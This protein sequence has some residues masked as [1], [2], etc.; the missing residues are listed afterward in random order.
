[1]SIMRAGK[2]QIESNKLL[3][4]RPEGGDNKILEM[5]FCDSETMHY[6][7][8]VWTPD[9]VAEALEWWHENWGVNNC[10]YGI[11]LIKDTLES[12]GT[13]G[14]T[15][16]S[17]PNEPGLELSWFVLP[18]YQRQGFATEITTELIRFAF[19][20][21]KAKRLVAETHP[22]NPASKKVLEKLHFECL[23][24]RQHSYDYL[25]GF[26]KQVLWALAQEKWQK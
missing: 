24:E 5:L 8:G 14:F 22:D 16:S 19:D 26:D 1:M 13:A 4:R 15:E 11:L 17:I 9:K 12:I 25:P 2:S 6:M 20:D 21:L 23:G 10:W 3:I 18:Q 7:G